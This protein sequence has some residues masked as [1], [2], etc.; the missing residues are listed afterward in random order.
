M[1]PG[2]V[3]GDW[4]GEGAVQLDT[5]TTSKK[6]KNRKYNPGLA[7]PGCLDLTM[8]CADDSLGRRLTLT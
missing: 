2:F 8:W 1:T 3:I 6:K 4:A 7:W 5:Y